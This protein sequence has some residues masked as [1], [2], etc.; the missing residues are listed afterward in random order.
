MEIERKF[1]VNTLPD[2]TAYP[3]KKLSQAYISTEPVIR[4]REMDSQFFLTVK[5]KGHLSREELEIPIS[6]EEYINL[7][8]KVEG[9]VIEKVRYYIP[10]NNELTAE[11]DIYHDFLE[12]LM[13]VEVEFSTEE[14]A[15]AFVP[16]SWFGKDIT[17][18]GRFKNN[19][20]A[21][22]GNP[23]KEV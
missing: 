13:T 14:A 4:L 17:F 22:D 15:N 10:L 16:P 5:S 7:Y 18:D 20:L 6:H 12:G 23:M 19:R 11:L 8:K 3:S 2:L 1:L 9:H 21:L